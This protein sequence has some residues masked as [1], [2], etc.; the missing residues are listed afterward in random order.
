MRKRCNKCKLCDQQAISTVKINSRGSDNPVVLFVGSSPGKE[1]DE[2]DL[3]F[4]GMYGRRLDEL[5]E[6]AGVSPDRCRWTNIVRCM[7]LNVAYEKFGGT[8]QPSEIEIDACSR[9]LEK[10]IL[11]T[12]PSY[13]VTLGGQALKYFLPKSTSVAKHRQKYHMIE[14]PTLRYRYRAFREWCWKS[15]NPDRAIQDHYPAD[16]VMN[17]QMEDAVDDGFS[18]IQTQKFQLWPTYLP[19]P[20]QDDRRQGDIYEQHLVEDLSFLSV[21][22]HGQNIT[23]PYDKYRL[24]SDLDDISD[25]CGDIKSRFLDGTIDCISLDV[26]TSDLD[27]YLSPNPELLLFSFSVSETET[28]TI[29]FNHPESPFNGDKFALEAI[30]ANMN[31][32]LEVVPVVGH[33]FKF[34]AH[35]L[36]WEGIFPKEVAGDTLLASYTL[37]NDTIAH[38]LESLV[39]KYTGMINHKEEMETAKRETPP[40]MPLE[41]KYIDRL[42]QGVPRGCKRAKDGIV[43]R[44]QNYGD[45]DMD[46][47]HRYCCADADGTLRLHRILNNLLHEEDLYDPH[48]SVSIPA[49][50]PITHMERDGIRVDMKKFEE[51]REH[52]IRSLKDLYDW[53]DRNGYVEQIRIIRTDQH[54]DNKPPKH[55]LM[56]YYVNKA[57]LLYDIL[58]LPLCKMKDQKPRTTNKEWMPE[59]RSIVLEHTK[60]SKSDEDTKYWQTRLDVVDKLIE[61]AIDHKTLTSWVEKIPPNCDVNDIGHAQFGIRTTETFRLKCKGHP[62]WHGIKRGSVVKECVVPHHKDGLIGVFDYSQMELCILANYC[63]D[64]AM[65]QAFRDKKDI[66]T[67]VAAMASGVSEE[68]VTKDIRSKMKAVSLGVAIGGRGSQA[69]ADQLGLSRNAAQ[70][71]IN[72][73]LNTFPSVRDYF[74]RQESYVLSEHKV[75]SEWGFRRIF[76]EGDYTDDELR[77][78]AINNPIQSTAGDITTTVAVNII[79]MMRKRKMKSTMWATVH[80]SLCLSIHPQELY[81]V[82]VLSKKMMEDWPA[83][84]LEWLIVP[85]RG[86]FEVGP[87]WGNTCTFNV[88]G[89]HKVS[90]TGSRKNFG[91]LKK[92]LLRWDTPPSP[93]PGSIETFDIDGEPSIKSIWSFK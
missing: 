55:I 26:E 78:R 86:D 53:F 25:V 1:E 7:P 82:L 37:F 81:K 67:F 75:M 19:S 45:L 13:I 63:K 46:M 21:K 60:T 48:Y 93:V 24:L 10:E 84:K 74:N 85:L 22:I 9:Y 61:F 17:K 33:N 56:G 18:L 38:D 54:K 91:L 49:I 88:L 12:R 51:V 71:I 23:I 79:K 34:D 58:D 92:T 68:E 69:V 29:P 76:P 5:M 35:W 42:G 73:Y 27:C 47:L 28:Y 80:D 36:M 8:R 4:L 3:A 32:M 20:P 40:W 41:Q 57:I 52:L 77:R 39:T 83:E 14:I 43:Y 30:K 15:D 65:I 87:T 59:L 90:I 50:L 11:I 72:Q 70:D 44:K 89:D 64:E 16:S 66:H 62:N 31:D 2:E 6:I